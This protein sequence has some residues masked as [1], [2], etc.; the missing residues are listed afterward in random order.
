M[1]RPDPWYV[2]AMSADEFLLGMLSLGAPLDASLVGA[3][4][5]PAATGRGSRR[6]VDLPLHRDGVRSEALAAIQGG[7]YVERPGV[8]V[9]G[10]YCLREG[11]APC[12]TT[13]SCD[14]ALAEVCLKRGEALILDNNRVSHGRRG[15]VGSRVLLRV[16]VGCS[17]PVEAG[18]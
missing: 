3:F 6:D 4:D 15:P 10:L 2:Q 7:V 1:R 18:K 16:W 13:L 8:D 9:V 12:F 5:D 14:D 17:V 11:D